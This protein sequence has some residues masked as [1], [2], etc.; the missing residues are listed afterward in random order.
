MK[1]IIIGA[2][3]GKR[4]GQ[5]AEKLPKALLDVNGKT[6]LERQL[7]LFRKNGIYDIVVITGPHNEKFNFDKIT[8]VHDSQY[9]KHDILGSLMM[10]REHIK[11]DVLIT[12]SDILFE[13]NILHQIMKSRSDI[14]IAVDL[15]W[16][17][18]YLNRTEH[19]PSEAENVLLNN[20]GE[21]LQ[22]RKNIQDE[23]KV[24]EFLGIIKLSPQGSATFVKEF[25][26]V[27][28]SHEG[29]F[30]CA[31]S[32]HKAYLTDMIQEIIDSKIMVTPITISGKWCEIDTMQDL[33]RARNLFN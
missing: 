12:Y 21:V 6:I 25:E 3:S 14:G 17:K 28:H 20:S 22:I 18:S 11:G 32:I 19:P 8:Y 2:G 4:V 27:E 29:V 33:Q 31:S 15:D 10:A 9:P 16:K 30:H 26:R 23:N 24:A 5:F 7:N 1:V 13:E